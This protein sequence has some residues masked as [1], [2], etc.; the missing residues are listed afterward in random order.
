MSD[1]GLPKP[2]TIDLWEDKNGRSPFDKWFQKLPEYEQAVVDA[3][4]KHVLAP[5][6]RDIC[7]T[8]WGKSLG[9]GLY[10]LRIGVSLNA[11]LNRGKSPEDQVSIDGGDK[12]ILLRIFCTFH[13]QR[14]VLLFQGYNKGKDPSKKRQQS[15]IKRAQ[16]HLKAWKQEV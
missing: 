4:I 13:G 8:T 14:V 1:E 2:W 3:T 6:G 16:K 10:E 15:E 9:D 7:E 12:T 11:I 5:L